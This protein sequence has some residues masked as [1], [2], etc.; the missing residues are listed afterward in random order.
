[1]LLRLKS[2]AAVAQ[3]LLE[4]ELLFRDPLT[5]LLALVRK[6]ALDRGGAVLPLGLRDLLREIGGELRALS[7]FGLR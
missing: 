1:M 3:R 4:R 7:R 2:Q 5:E 6:S